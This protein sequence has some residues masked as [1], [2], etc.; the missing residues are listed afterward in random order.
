MYVLFPKTSLIKLE[1]NINIKITRIS[2]VIGLLSIN[3]TNTRSN[4]IPILAT[5]F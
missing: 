5:I 1:E 3:T 2:V 4:I